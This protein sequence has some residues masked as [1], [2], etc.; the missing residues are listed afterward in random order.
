MNKMKSHTGAGKRIK[1]TGSGKLMRVKAGKSHLLEK[2]SSNRKGTLSQ[3][4]SVH[5]SREKSIR[6]S[7]A[8]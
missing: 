4:T 3:S 8:I 2:K 7:L 6:R 5:K 1:V